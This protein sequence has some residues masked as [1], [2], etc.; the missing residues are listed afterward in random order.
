MPE[1]QKGK[2]G[3]PFGRPAG[4]RNKATLALEQLL[5]GEGDRLMRKAVEL[6]LAGDVGAL[7]LCLERIVP[8]RRDR[9]V[10]FK[11]PEL[12]SIG[13]ASSAVKAM[14]EA[15]AA[16]DLSPMEAN[17]LS[18]LVMAF[19]KAVETTEFEARLKA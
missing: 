8:P 4:S 9:V 15:V 19:V 12:S 18:A 10:R 17:D 11:L 5:D 14:I 16:G 1:F 3:N 2:S 6:A 7:R 13:T